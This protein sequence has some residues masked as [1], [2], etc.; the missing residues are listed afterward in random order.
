VAADG[1]EPECHIERLGVELLVAMGHGE[2][3]AG[4]QFGAPGDGGVDGVINLDK[5]G[6]DKVGI[7]SKR[8][9]AGNIIGMPSP[10][11]MKWRAGVNVSCWDAAPVEDPHRRAI[12]PRWLRS[13]LFFA[14]VAYDP[15]LTFW[16]RNDLAVQIVLLGILLGGGL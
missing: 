8:Y 13:P 15:S 4:K 7:Q 3:K 2:P 14:A 6:L 10:N 5:I 1:R 11:L 16:L 9:A 12:I